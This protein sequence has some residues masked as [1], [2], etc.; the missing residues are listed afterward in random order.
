MVGNP[1]VFIKHIILPFTLISVVDIAINSVYCGLFVNILH[2]DWS[3]L[4]LVNT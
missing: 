2:S 1:I 4:S 3:L